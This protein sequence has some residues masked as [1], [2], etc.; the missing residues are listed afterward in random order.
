MHAAHEQ[1]DR[2]DCR[3]QSPTFKGEAGTE[4]TRKIKDPFSAL[5]PGPTQR[6]GSRFRVKT[7]E[8]APVIQLDM[9][10]D[11]ESSLKAMSVAFELLR[12]TT[13][14]QAKQLVDA[15]NEKIVGVIVT[16]K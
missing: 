7:A 1:L 9:F 6:S 4:T 2:Y 16:L 13:G 8:G 12:G 5:S 14:D 11:K 15:M 10:D 3:S